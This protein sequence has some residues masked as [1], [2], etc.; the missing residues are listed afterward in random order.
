MNLKKKLMLIFSFLMAT[1]L[2]LI[3]CSAYFY[4]EKMLKNEIEKGAKAI[5]DASTKDLDG[6][7]Y[8]KAAVV[9]TKAMTIQSLAGDGM[10][11][12][13]MLLG[14]D[15]ADKEISDLYF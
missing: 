11:T 5:V 14:F 2:V 1:L 15:Q 10:V 7:L 13:P 9:K 6:W 3:S 4:T 12:L 8:G